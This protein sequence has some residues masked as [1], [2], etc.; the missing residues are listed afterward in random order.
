MVSL[1]ASGLRWA[2]VYFLEHRTQSD[3]SFV[4][5]ILAA[6]VCILVHIYAQWQIALRSIAV[7]RITAKSAPTY[8]EA[9]HYAC[10][11]VGQLILVYGLAVLAPALIIGFW[12]LFDL[13]IAWQWPNNIILCWLA[14]LLLAVNGI[15]LGVSF[16][17]VLLWCSLTLCV[18]ACENVPLLEIFKRA[19]SLAKSSLIRGIC[20]MCLLLIC[21]FALQTA[22]QLPILA[23][24]LI[25]VIIRGITGSPTTV[26]AVYH[27]S[28]FAEMITVFL[29]SLIG[30]LI[31]SIGCATYAIYYLDLR[32]RLEGV[33]IV[34]KIEAMG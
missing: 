12:L 7:M 13:L 2:G 19:F 31:C 20:F 28:A 29:S 1:S 11:K 33:D 18:L 9:Y 14:R 17:W 3:W 26:S 15:A 23:V 25:D 30:I 5:G 27:P 34:N 21:I 22:C 6:L 4:V 16:V 8:K 24:R 10:S 32:Q